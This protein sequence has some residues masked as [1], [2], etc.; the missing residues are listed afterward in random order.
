MK[1]IIIDCGYTLQRVAILE[2]GKFAD[3]FVE[4]KQKGSVL[5]NIYK[6]R[7]VNVLPGMGAA[8]IDIGLKKNAYL[9]KRYIVGNKENEINMRDKSIK[10]MIKQGQDIIVQIIKEPIG[11]KGAKV[12]TDISIPGKYIVLMPKSNTIS[13]SRKIKDER[14]R[15]RLKDIAREIKLEGMGMILR[16]E[17]EGKTKKDLKKDINFL[18]KIQQKI[19]LEG[20]LGFPPKLLYEDLD[21]IH[22]ISR[23]YLTNDV[24]KLV[25]NKK[26]FYIDLKQF[27]SHTVPDFEKKIVLYDEPYNI[28]DEYGLEVKVKE[29][30]EKRV[31][32]SNGGY[33]LIDETEALTVIDVNTGKF[34]GSVREEKTILET[35]ILAAIESARQLKLRNIGGII[36]IDFIDMKKKEDKKYLINIFNKELKRDKLASKV[37][38]ITKL[39][40]IEITRKKDTG[41]TSNKLMDHCSYCKGTGKVFKGT[42]LIDYIE[43]DI[44]VM[45][46]HTNTRNIKIAV[47]PYMYDRLKDNKLF[48]ELEKIHDM[49]IK[50]YS[51]SEIIDNEYKIKTHS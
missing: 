37:L 50:L 27:I 19:S 41:K 28:F 48:L 26:D 9:N 6:G 33:L 5:G 45:K 13:I 32:L 2:D 47:S 7:V 21:L 25:I 11:G 8:F 40:L 3:F 1:D 29:L 43:K 38:G 39:G 10:D 31:T 34:V 42:T 35:N 49:N 36:I 17:A 24:K 18:S 23:E 15:K 51:S 44:R 4:D 20:N 16:T 14:E 22:R 12:T 46:F 30:F